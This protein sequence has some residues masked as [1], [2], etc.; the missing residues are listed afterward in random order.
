MTSRKEIIKRLESIQENIGGLKADIGFGLDS[1]NVKK[2]IQHIVNSLSRLKSGL[3]D[4]EVLLP[5]RGL[6]EYV[7]GDDE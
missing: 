5:K 7:D 1:F 6:R 3:Y 2:D 4:T